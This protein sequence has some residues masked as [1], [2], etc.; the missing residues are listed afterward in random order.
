MVNKFFLFLF[1]FLSAFANLLSDEKQSIINLL[2][3][4]Q[5]LNF[6][7]VQ[8]INEKIESG[9]C[10]LVFDNKLKCSYTDEKE[11]LINNKTLVV[12]K[13]KYRKNYFYP[14]SKSIFVK[15]LNKESL[16]NLIQNSDLELNEKINLTYRSTDNGKIT[17]FFKREN[18]ELIG[19]KIVDGLQNKIFFSLRI[20]STNNDYDPIIFSVPERN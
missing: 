17:I 3:Q 1:I 4:T 7:F 20:Q 18:Y 9:N 16:I 12:I 13:K 2:N 14:I 11:V 10:I 6:N 8:N 5:N 15:I 19:W